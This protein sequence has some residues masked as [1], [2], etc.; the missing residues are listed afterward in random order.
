L[1]YND[2]WSNLI[3]NQSML[4]KRAA[5]LFTDDWLFI[6]SELEKVYLNGEAVEHQNQ[7]LSLTGR[8]KGYFNLSLS[9]ISGCDGSAE[10]IFSIAAETTEQ[11]R[12]E[13]RRQDIEKAIQIET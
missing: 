7:P 5:E 9:P 11:V 3:G 13:K 10:G 2:A 4:G 8:D 12:N 6:G 1:L